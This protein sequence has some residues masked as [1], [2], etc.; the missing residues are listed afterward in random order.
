[1]EININSTKVPFPYKVS[2]DSEDWC[3]FYVVDIVYRDIV[4]TEL[5]FSQVKVHPYLKMS[6]FEF[7]PDFCI[8][9]SN[10]SPKAVR[11]L[12][13]YDKE[14]REVILRH[15]GAQIFAHLHIKETG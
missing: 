7:V 1:M 12:M 5:T 2:E 15:V 9:K 14:D 11:A 6:T 13:G 3:D 4:K 8:K 10:L